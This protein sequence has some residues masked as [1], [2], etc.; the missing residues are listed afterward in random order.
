MKIKV[1]NQEKP[2]VVTHYNY[3]V[4]INLSHAVLEPVEE[5]VWEII[6]GSTDVVAEFFSLNYSSFPSS[7]SFF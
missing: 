6:P 3:C 1:T 2:W 4:T 7:H 5:V